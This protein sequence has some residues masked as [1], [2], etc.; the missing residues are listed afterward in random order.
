MLSC[1]EVSQLAS[2][3]LDAPL[4]WRERMG[5]RLHLL[6]CRLCRRYVRNLLLLE[7]MLTDARKVDLEPLAAGVKLSDEGRARMRRALEDTH[8]P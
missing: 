5:M 2:K 1:K 8:R 7:Q 6:I 3:T 4:T